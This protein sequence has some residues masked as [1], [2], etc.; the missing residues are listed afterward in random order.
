MASIYEQID[1]IADMEKVIQSLAESDAINSTSGAFVDTGE[2]IE[3]NRLLTEVG[4]I[5]VATTSDM[6]QITQAMSDSIKVGNEFLEIARVSGLFDDSLG[7]LETLGNQGAITFD[8]LVN[9]VVGATG[10]IN[11]EFSNIPITLV[12]PMAI[13]EN[14][15]LVALTRITQMVSGLVDDFVAMAPIVDKVAVA[16]GNLVENGV[17]VSRV[18]AEMWKWL[19]DDNTVVERALR[20]FLFFENIVYNIFATLHNIIGSFANW[21]KFAFD[22]PIQA[23]QLLFCDMGAFILGVINKVVNS[24]SWLLNQ[25]PLVDIGVV[26]V[27]SS[28]IDALENKRQLLIEELGYKE[29]DYMEVK[30]PFEANAPLEE[31]GFNILSMETSLGNIGNI[32]N[33]DNINNNTAPIPTISDSMEV[34]TEDMNFLKALVQGDAINRYTTAE[35]KIEQTNQNNINSNMDIEGVTNDLILGLEEARA[36][37]KEGYSYV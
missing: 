15:T 2:L 29:F 20:G 36:I 7:E 11:R 17:L 30:N 22:Y 8:M 10:E 14:Q 33:I 4:N 6:E 31:L 18:M 24:V 19:G 23:I 3:F 37:S 28:K 9:S 5:S 13:A 1:M 26:E 25:I 16:L 12:Q 34:S 27:G 35:I 21:L 32:G